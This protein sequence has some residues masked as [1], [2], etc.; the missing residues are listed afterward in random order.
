MREDYQPDV[1][2]CWRKSNKLSRVVE[3]DPATNSTTNGDETLARRHAS[4][5]AQTTEVS[6]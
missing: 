6:S 4:E 3:I 2:P 5:G 1:S